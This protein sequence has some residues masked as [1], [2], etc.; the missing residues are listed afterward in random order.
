VD[1]CPLFE[2]A[3]EFFYFF[4]LEAYGAIHSSIERVIFGF[5]DIIAG[6]PFGAALAHDDFTGMH[7]LAGIMLDAAALAVA[8]ATVLGFSC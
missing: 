2:P 1:K 7:R 8:V 5:T 4:L 6:M 3:G